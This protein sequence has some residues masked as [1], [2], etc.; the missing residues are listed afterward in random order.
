ML[1]NAER[2]A[3]EV[4]VSMAELLVA[5]VPVSSHTNQ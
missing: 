2:L 4:D 3:L 5:A 1:E